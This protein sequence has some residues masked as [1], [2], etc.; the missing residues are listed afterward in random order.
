MAVWNLGGTLGS[1]LGG[2][3]GSALGG[4]W[5]RAALASASLIAIGQASAAQERP[6]TPTFV[7][8]GER[9]NI[10]PV[11][12]G[13]AG[14]PRALSA[15]RVRLSIA[16]GPL[17]PALASLIART[18]LSLA[19]RTALTENRATR[20]V[21]GDVLPLEALARL[22]DGTGLTYRAAKH[23][24]ITLVNPRYAQASLPPGDSNAPTPVGAAAASVTLDELSV[25]A[26][27][28]TFGTTGFVATRST[29]GSKG[30]DSILETPATVSVITRDELNVRGVQDVNLAVAYTPNVQAVDY[31]GGQGGPTFTLRGF[32][33]NNFDS[34]YEDGLRYG[35]NSFDQNIEPYAYERI[36]VVKGPIS[37]LYGQGQPGGIINLVSKRPTFVPF[38]EVFLQGGN[39]GRVQAGFDLSGPVE[40]APQ[41]AYRVTGLVR[42][43]DSQVKYTPDDRTFIAPAL[44]W[45]P[46]A[47][48]ALTVLGKYAEYRGGG[49]EQSL[50]IVGSILPSARGFFP[51]SPFVGQPNFNTGLLENKEIGYILDHSFAPGWLLHAAFRAYETTSKFDAVGASPAFTP[52]GF[53]AVSVFPYLRDQSS[54]GL[55]T[56]NYVQ[57]RFDTW[58][59]QHDVVL[60]VGFQNYYRRD[61][62]TFPNGYP[63]SAANRLIDLYDPVYNLGIAFPQRT[64]VATRALQQQ[65]GAYLQDQMKWNG[66]ILTGSLR[67]DWVEQQVRTT[68]N[69]PNLPVATLNR[70][71]I[72]N[73]NFSALSYRAALGYEFAAGIVPYAAYSTS[74]NPQI[75][76]QRADG[77]ALP[78][79]E[80]S[81]IEGGVKWQP[82]DTN[83]L[84]TASYFEI[85]QTN[86]PLAD[87]LNPGF[88]IVTGAAES[89]GFE[90]EG[91]ASLFDGFNLIFG[92]AHLNTK[93]TR[94]ATNPALVGNRLPNAP[95]NTLS[96]FADYTLPLNSPFAGF[97]AGAGVR[98]VGER[99]DATNVDRIPAYALVDASL[100]YDLAQLNPAWKGAVL[101][102]NANNIF[103][104]RYFTSG[105]YTGYVFEGF[106]RSVFGTLTYRW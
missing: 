98:Y 37:V 9:L 68:F 26:Q 82:V 93:V 6:I 69:F 19:Y 10:V 15:R 91:K 60:G 58:D 1:A 85:T 31:P 50:P 30:N 7:R 64:N 99:T 18:G 38:N 42:N 35:F 78:P 52:P 105:F 17:E 20:G 24:T 71:T 51:R 23:A 40:G 44:T 90:L 5:R 54:Q 87:P 84:V 4:T 63:T 2:T 104:Q 32:N 47:D 43:A 39:Y 70:T 100:N 59:I 96:L 65:T 29:A 28:P 86:I 57:G 8:A 22:L 72:D 14:P 3:L 103:D 46:D 61:A 81:Q 94:N 56:D 62:R 79:R 102:V 83:A 41:F 49:S 36:D 74:F 95:D 53:L 21:E 45:R 66:F 48:T 80:A 92:Y 75:A 88:F 11:A 77:S 97:R 33:A 16:P 101:S 13:D 12:A 73:Q 67:N 55:L 34:V 27:Q 76:G 25:E 106:R 89:R